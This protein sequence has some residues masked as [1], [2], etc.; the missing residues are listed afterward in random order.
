MKTC[1]IVILNYNTQ[2][3]LQEFL[4]KVIEHS[5]IAG[6]KVVV[7]DNASTDNSVEYMKTHWPEIELIQ[8][9]SNL[10]F[11]GGYNYV[12]QNRIADYF[13]LLNSDVVTT[14][15]WLEPILDLLNNNLK[16]AA[17]QPKLLDYSRPGNFEYAGACGGFID[18]LGFPFCRGR[19][20]GNIETDTGQYNEPVPVFWATGAALCVRANVWKTANGLDAK[21]FAHMEEIDLCWRIQNMGYSIY[22]EPKSSVYHVG[23]GTLSNT[24]TRKTFL[25]Y[26]NNLYML[27]KNLSPRNRNKIIL[28]R[29]FL[30]ALAAFHFILSGKAKHIFAIIKAHREFEKTKHT[31]DQLGQDWPQDGVLKYSLVYAYFVKR[32]TTFTKLKDLF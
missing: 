32:K 12:L 13:L 10:G 28:K 5:S 3:Y 2:Y 4:P 18:Y 6:V 14:E 20:F 11:A 8:I 23:G 7:A 30:D 31:L 21:F 24:N 17:V 27:Y 16:I 1:D 19:I 25:N 26:R 15:G 29:K 9:D 22:V